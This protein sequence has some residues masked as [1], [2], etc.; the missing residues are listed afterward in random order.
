MCILGSLYTK[1]SYFSTGS[2]KSY[3]TFTGSIDSNGDIIGYIEVGVL[4][5][6]DRTS[7]VDLVGNINDQIKGSWDDYFDVN[8]QLDKK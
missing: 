8:I 2:K 6:K 5:G 7:H 1:N 3:D 4:Y